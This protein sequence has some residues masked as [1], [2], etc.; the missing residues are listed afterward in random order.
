MEVN[1]TFKVTLTGSEL[2]LI[3]LALIGGLHGPNTQ[4]AK[5]LNEK[6]LVSRQH[7]IDSAVRAN[8]LAKQRC[9]ISG[10]TSESE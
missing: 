3:S 1:F 9:G 10:I 6:L 4:L 8:E 5:E 2:K 7:A